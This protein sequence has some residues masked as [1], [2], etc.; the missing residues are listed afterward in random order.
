VIAASEVAW[1]IQKLAMDSEVRSLADVLDDEL[2]GFLRRLLVEARV[3]SLLVSVFARLQEPIP[4][5][6]EEVVDGLAD[7]VARVIHDAFSTSQQ[8]LSKEEWPQL[9]AGTVRRP[10][11]RALLPQGPE[12]GGSPN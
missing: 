7:E 10:D 4:D 5:L 1:G 2:L 11:P 6:S 8:A 3:E 12:Q 9:D